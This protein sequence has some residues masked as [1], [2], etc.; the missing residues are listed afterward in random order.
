MKF[1]ADIML[2]KLAKWLRI[3]GIDVIYDSKISDQKLIS[4]AL[5][6]KR[7]ILTRDTKLLRNK[8]LKDY[9]FIFSDHLREQLAQV[10]DYYHIDPLEKG[11]TRCIICNQGLEKGRK[12]DVKDLVAPYV[13]AT[14]KEFSQCPQCHK[15]YWPGTHKD[16]ML[17]K[18]SAFRKF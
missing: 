6:E 7:T 10:I 11:F 4:L 17:S 15:V 8:S 18:L 12:E 9:L 16:D 5:Q 14:Q 13:Y 1:I 2:G 3:M